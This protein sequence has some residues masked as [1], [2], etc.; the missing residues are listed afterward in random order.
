MP[1]GMRTLALLAPLFL[2]SAGLSDES[3][4]AHYEA[5]LQFLDQGKYVD[6]QESFKAGI[7]E[8]PDSPEIHNALGLVALQTGEPR[9]AVHSFERAVELR[10]D[11][12]QIVYNLISAYLTCNQPVPALQK[13]DQLLASK[14]ADS[15]LLVQAGELLSRF[16]HAAPAAQCYR[17]AE[18]GGRKAPAVRFAVEKLLVEV[19]AQIERDRAEINQLEA[20]LQANRG[21]PE[22]YFQLGLMWIK[23]GQFSRSLELLEP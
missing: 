5:G 19:D 8:N 1:S 15:A 13:T 10:P 20:E 22:P 9:S 21:R 16:G 17:A 23:L 4:K 3:W 6:A 12:G 2:A 11:D 14:T 18:E 7:A